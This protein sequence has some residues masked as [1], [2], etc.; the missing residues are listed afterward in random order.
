MRVSART[1]RRHRAA[2]AWRYGRGRPPAAAACHG[3][4]LEI[5]HL[6]QT[7]HLRG[8]C[9][10]FS[11]AAPTYLVLAAAA[12]PGAHVPPPA[13]RRPGCSGWSAARLHPPWQALFNP[14][15]LNLA[16]PGPRLR[17]VH[18]LPQE[19]TAP[20]LRA[21]VLPPSHSRSSACPCR[22]CHAARS[23][24]HGSRRRG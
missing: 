7:A 8:R 1:G 15:V 16:A 19:E 10:E 23:A 17:D 18:L 21:A 9:L 20:Q 6:V 5:D 4:G 11:T 2:A 22:S 13:A 3:L 24:V 14:G 12:A